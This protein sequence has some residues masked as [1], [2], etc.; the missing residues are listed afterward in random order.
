MKGTI[1][2][3]WIEWIIFFAGTAFLMCLFTAVIQKE[4]D[5]TLVYRIFLIIFL[6]VWAGVLW[7]MPHQPTVQLAV[8]SSLILVFLVAVAFIPRRPPKGRHETL[9]LLDQIEK[10]RKLESEFKKHFDSAFWI[11]LCLLI[12]AIVIRYINI[13]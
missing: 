2:M 4:E 10:E 11:V 9:D 7:R 1:G 3:T 13:F 8:I 5:R 12:S 6:S